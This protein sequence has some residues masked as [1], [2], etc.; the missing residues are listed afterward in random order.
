MG[1]AMMIVDVIAL[2]LT[3]AIPIGVI[4]WVWR[5]MQKYKRQGVDDSVASPTPRQRQLKRLL[6]DWPPNPKE[7]RRPEEGEDQRVVLQSDDGA[8]LELLKPQLEAR[9]IACDVQD[10]PLIAH[11]GRTTVWGEYKLVVWSRDASEAQKIVDRLW[12]K[13]LRSRD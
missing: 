1:D 2:S 7:S 11:T 4:W 9:G 5:W 10:R 3:A 6:E 13:E 12:P 8:V